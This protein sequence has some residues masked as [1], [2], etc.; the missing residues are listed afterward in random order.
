VSS[1]SFWVIWEMVELSALAARVR[2]VFEL[3]GLGE[4]KRDVCDERVERNWWHGLRDDEREI[5]LLV[6]K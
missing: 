3:M 5:K 2:V 6:A 4:T 1:F